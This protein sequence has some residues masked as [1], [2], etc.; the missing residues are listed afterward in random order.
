VFCRMQK[1]LNDCIRHH[2]QIIR[3][4]CYQLHAGFLIGYSSTLEMEMTCY[5]VTP[6]HFQRTTWRYIP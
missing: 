2:Q 1:Q 5:S 3:Y 6:I 4:V